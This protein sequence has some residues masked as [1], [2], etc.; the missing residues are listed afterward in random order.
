M[1]RKVHS[2]TVR[3]SAIVAG[4][5]SA[6]V[7]VAFLLIFGGNISASSTPTDQATDRT[8]VQ[9]PAEHHPTSTIVDVVDQAS[10]SV[11]SII[12]SED[13]PQIERFYQEGPFGLRIPRQEIEGFERQQVG[14]GSGFFVSE[15]GLIVTNRHVVSNPD[16]SYS[17]VT[18]DG[19]TYELEVVGRDPFLDIAVLETQNATTT[20][21]TLAFG[22][23][24]R[25]SP[26]QSVIAIGNAL[27][28]F[29]N[30]VSVGVVS[31]LGR[32]VVAGGLT[33]DIQR[34]EQVIQT[35][36]AIN[37]GNSGG[38]L[39]N[40][41][42]EVVGVNVAIAQASENISFALPS[43]LVAE[44]VNSVEEYGEIV[45]PFLGVRFVPI[46][47]AIAARRDLSV[48]QGALVVPG[49]DG[50]AVTPGSAADQA[51]IQEGDIITSFGGQELT[52]ANNLGTLIRNFEVGETV[53]IELQRDGEQITLEA[54]LQRAPETVR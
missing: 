37:P 18:S 50:Q 28:E 46:N 41:Q 51:G 27:G 40:L 7:A 16:A 4:L 35:D 25:L 5:V 30:S 20:F 14:S 11:V 43:N 8:Q 34:L 9:Q 33:G 22:D 23:S 52:E 10:P 19:T 17:A 54:T 21:P 32:S 2:P 47:D 1:S 48:S 38:P 24:G 15:D 49:P 13:V 44:V 31:G 45:R 26:G 53:Q 6:I 12:V 3:K 42:G 39:L 36:A 29:Q